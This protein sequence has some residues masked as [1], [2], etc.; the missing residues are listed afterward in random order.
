MNHLIIH[1]HP[2]PT[3]FNSSIKDKIIEIS[4]AS[5]DNVELRDLYKINF[6][7]ALQYTDITELRKGELPKDVKTEQEYIK[8]AD[9]ISIVYPIWWM[10]MPAILKGYFDRVFTNGFAFIF[11]EHGPIGLLNDKNVYL[12]STAGLHQSMY[13]TLH[14]IENFNMII[15]YGVFEFCEMNVKSHK[16]FNSVP[17]VT[18]SER[19]EML[20]NIKKMVESYDR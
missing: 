17:F 6:N 18:D 3:S 12:Y 11:K 1:S 5:G 4:K 16:Y 14:L 19:K 2:K 13:D 7:P 15:D 10:S 9:T 20:S 8:W